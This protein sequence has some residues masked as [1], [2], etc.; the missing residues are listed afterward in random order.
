MAQAWKTER[1]IFRAIEDNEADHAFL[2]EHIANDPALR[3]TWTPKTYRPQSRDSTAAFFHNMRSRLLSVYICL[4]LVPGYNQPEPIG[5]VNLRVEGAEH[6]HNRDA[7]LGVAI[8]DAHQGKGY[9][10]EVINWALDWAFKFGNLHRVGLDCFGFNHRG[11]K[12]Y[13]RLGFI[14]EGTTRECLWFDRGWHDV[15]QY[16]MLE[17]E[18]ETLRKGDVVSAELERNVG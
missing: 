17:S 9:G 2:T 12:V 5:F 3:A 6:I 15:I 10:P 13:E 18:W 1:L 7:I 11:Q 4:P 16:G 8:I 14:K